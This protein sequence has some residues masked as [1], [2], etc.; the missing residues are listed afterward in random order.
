MQKVKKKRT[1]YD[2]YGNS[3]NVHPSAVLPLPS[4]GVTMMMKILNCGGRGSD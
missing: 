1:K 4:L 3:Q 2:G